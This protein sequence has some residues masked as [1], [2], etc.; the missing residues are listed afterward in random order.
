MNKPNFRL[1]K[2]DDEATGSLEPVAMILN[3]QYLN[4]TSST[5]SERTFCLTKCS[6][7]GYTCRCDTQCGCVGNKPKPT[8]CAGHCGRV[9]GCVSE[10]RC[11]DHTPEDGK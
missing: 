4:T 5:A 9:C 3:E 8:Y 1:D 7:D 6:T 2:V 10:C 11:E